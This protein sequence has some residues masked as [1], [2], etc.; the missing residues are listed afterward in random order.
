MPREKKPRDRRV[1]ALSGG[2]L[3]M[4]YSTRKPHVIYTWEK[5]VSNT[6]VA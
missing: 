1:K 4:N 5:W 6:T 2:V 3:V